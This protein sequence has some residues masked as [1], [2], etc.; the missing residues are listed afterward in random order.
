MDLL[1]YGGIGIAGGTLSGILGIG[2]G[3]LVVPAFI[4]LCGMSQH[5]A[6][7]T[8]LAMLLPPISLFAVMIYLRQGNVHLPAAVAG[9][10]GFVLGSGIGAYGASLLNAVVLQ[11]LFGLVLLAVALHM[12]TG[13]P[14]VP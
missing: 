12:L 10:A 7:G 9:A 2:G 6:Q 13:R 8:T 3:I 11:K 14:S 4:Y 1:L 5:Q